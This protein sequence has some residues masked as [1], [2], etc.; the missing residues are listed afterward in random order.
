[1]RLPGFR[2]P[3]PQPSKFARPWG[4]VG[5]LSAQRYEA[6]A[7]ILHRQARCD[8]RLCVSILENRSGH[9]AV[10]QRFCTLHGLISKASKPEASLFSL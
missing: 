3:A 6:S 4:H 7:Q 10:S 1:M 9:H 8:F 2:G 5:A